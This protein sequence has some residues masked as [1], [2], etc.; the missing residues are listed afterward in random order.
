MADKSNASVDLAKHYRR[1]Y[2]EAMTLLFWMAFC[3]KIANGADFE[4]VPDL[5]ISGYLSQ[6][7]AMDMM[8]QYVKDHVDDAIGEAR[9]TNDLRLS[10]NYE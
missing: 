2:Q 7:S 10:G 8:S 4:D 5:P 9:K 3:A 1:K 6:E